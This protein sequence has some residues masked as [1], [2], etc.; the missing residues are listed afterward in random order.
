MFDVHI[1][2]YVFNVILSD[3]ND[4]EIYEQYFSEFQFYN[5]V[6]SHDEHRP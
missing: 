3:F 2:E 1:A 5:I 6:C 4:K